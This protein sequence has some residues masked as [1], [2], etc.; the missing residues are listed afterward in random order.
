MHNIYSRKITYTF[1][2]LIGIICSASHISFSQK[3]KAKGNENYMDFQNKSFY[4]GMAFGTSFS[5]F[6]VNQSELI[7]SEANGI[8]LVEGITKGGFNIHMVSNLK[9]GEYFDF[10]FNPGFS[11]MYRDLIFNDNT[12]KKLESVYFETPFGIRF[13]SM[14]YN[15]KRAFVIAGLKYGYDVSSN[16]NSRR[17]ENLIRVTPHDFQWEVGVGMQFYYPFFIFSP[18]IKVGR[19][20][21]N[22]LIYNRTLPESRAIDQISTQVFTIT[23]NF[24]G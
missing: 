24:E 7:Y 12:V 13:K 20:L 22:S 10:R 17:G 16:A 11:F 19:G 18:E 4:F 9:M 8:K 14:P 15:D 3:I 21:N 23:F 6:R 5:K 2:I 1:F